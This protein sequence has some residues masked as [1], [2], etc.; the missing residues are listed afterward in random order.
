MI[1]NQ[2]KNKIEN[3]GNVSPLDLPQALVDIEL[4][5]QETAKEM[6]DRIHADFQKEDIVNNVVTPVFTTMI[7]GVLAHPRFKRIA[8]KTG[9]SAQRVMRECKDFNYDGKIVSLMPDAFVEY[10]NEKDYQEL[11]KKDNRSVYIRSVYENTSAMNRYK[12]SKVS[13]KGAKKNLQDEYRMTNDTTPEK[14][15]PDGRRKDPLNL[16]NTETDHIVPLHT[17][18]NQLQN[19]SAL[20]DGDIKRIA[21]QDYNF[22]VTARMVN[23]P[24]RDMSNSEFIAEQDK[25]KAEGKPYVELSPEVRANMIKMEKEAQKAINRSVN[26]TV[27]N[28]LLGKGQ[29]DRKERKAAMENREKELGRKLTPKE[30]ATVDREL[31]QKKAMDIH[32]GNAAQAGKQSLMYAIGTAV[33]FVF[34]PLYYEIKDGIIAG[35]QEGVCANTYKEAFTIRFNRVKEYVWGQLKDLKKILGSAMDMLKN[36]LSA[37]IEGLIG[38]FV[39]IFKK[40]FKVLK[41]GVRVFIQ[42]WPILF[43]EQSKAMTASQKG[44]AILKLVAGSVVAL[45]GIGI[46]VL[47]E[48]VPAIPEDLRGVMSVFLSGL[49]SVLV[50]YALD[51]ADLFNVK[52]ERRDQRIK[53]IFE[54]RVK[55]IKEATNNLETSVLETIRK[56]KIEFGI[57]MNQMSYAISTN[58]PKALNEALIKHA[59]LLGIRLECISIGDIQNKRSTLKWDL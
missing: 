6:M 48:K 4:Y 45:C 25:L 33:L 12:K 7:D 19:N 10:R 39:G 18:F 21:N 42:A 43:G 8:S 53:E 59:Q 14:N 56:Q 13:E 20:S 57:I 40:I 34:K 1:D 38:M 46:D 5:E 24:K 3:L 55:D 27:V 23:N 52:K 54:E 28:N 37:L 17:V 29:A 58:N 11:W 41:E 50:F 31:A 32:M 22:A 16:H 15:N 9:L 35:F 47:L 51:K 44:D 36:F 30:R 26:K 49:T 2:I